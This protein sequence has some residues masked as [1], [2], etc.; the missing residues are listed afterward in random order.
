MRKTPECK[1][2]QSLS[3]KVDLK[4]NNIPKENSPKKFFIESYGCQMNFNDSEIVASILS[5]KGFIQTPLPLEAELVLINTCSIREKA[6]VSVR[7]KLIEFKKRKKNNPGLLIGILG[8]MAERLKTKLLEEENLVDFVVGPD[9]YRNLPQIIGSAESGQKT[10]NVLLSREETYGDINPVRLDSNGVTAFV[11]I[12]RGCNNMCS[13]CVVPFTRGRERSR[14]PISILRECKELFDNGFR[15]ITLLGQNVDS[16]F[17]N[18]SITGEETN[19][20]GLLERVACI[21]LNLRVR[22][23]TSHPKDITD[24]VLFSMIKYRNICK[25]IHLPAQSGS[26]V[27]LKAMNR[28][29]T[30]EWYVKKVDRIREIIPECGLSTDIITGFCG[31]SE[32]D[33]SQTISL[34]KNCKF[35]LAYMFLYSE[36]PGT[37]AAKKF[38]DNIPHEI[39]LRRL[40]QIVELQRNLAIE[41]MQKEVGKTRIVLIEG[42]SKRSHDEWCGRTDQNKMVIF[43]K[44]EF[45]KGQYVAVEIISFTS[46]TLF[47]RAIELFKED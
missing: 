44:N 35:D 30:R 7:N 46:A 41:Q 18:D 2:I 33:H 40:K 28:C 39:K 16:Y 12:M 25:N 37:S 14:N 31:E 11:S 26:T 47:G 27:I 43:P 23:S 8:C 36:R 10:V 5:T 38:V 15:E 1:E 17:W 22:F 42:P 20:S 3:N 34:M 4:F 29:Y 6:E 13:F 24:E 32:E 45:C 19:F 9:S 21:N